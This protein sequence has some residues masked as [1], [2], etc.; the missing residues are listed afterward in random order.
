MPDR[1]SVQ[2]LL[3]ESLA[4][5]RR[6]GN[7]TALNIALF[8]RALVVQAQDDILLAA[9]QALSMTEIDTRLDAST[10]QSPEAEV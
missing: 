4:L 7:A 6:L 8:R 10:D 3:D 1:P 2:S 5:S 9:G